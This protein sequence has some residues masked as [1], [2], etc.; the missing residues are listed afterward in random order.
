[1]ARKVFL[2]EAARLA[3]SVVLFSMVIVGLGVLAKVMTTLLV[4]G[5]GILP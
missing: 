4:F 1:M 5:W 3:W 2:K